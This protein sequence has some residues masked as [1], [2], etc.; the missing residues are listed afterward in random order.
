MIT[1][2]TQHGLLEHYSVTIWPERVIEDEAN[3][4]FLNLSLR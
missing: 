4:Q 3:F 1:F 2:V